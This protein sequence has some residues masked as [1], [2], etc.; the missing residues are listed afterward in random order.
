MRIG[1]DARFFGPQGTGP[2]RYVQRLV[3]HLG[4]LDTPHTFVLFM[5]REGAN[6]YAPRGERFETVIA[7]Y[8]WYSVAEQLRMP[9][10][11]DRADL[12]LMHFPHFNVPV[13]YRKPFV[14]T[15]HDLI[16]THFATKRATTLGPIAYAFKQAGYRYVIR[17]AARHA[18][19]IL[20]VSEYSKRELVETFQL[21]PEH[22]RVTYEATDPPRELDEEAAGILDRYDVRQPFLLYVG[23]TYPHK[24]LERFIRGYA[25]YRERVTGPL[26]LVLVGKRDYFSRRLEA[27]ATKLGLHDAMQFVG[28]I[29]DAEL[30]AFYQAATW[31]VF[32]SLYEGFGLPPLEAMSYGTPVLSSNATCL[33]EILGDA[34]RY[35]SPYRS[36][37]IADALAE[38]HTGTGAHDA[39]R[40]QARAHVRQ[41]SWKRMAEETL[42]VYETVGTDLRK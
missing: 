10:V 21:D 34:V 38:A 4:R 35:F 20:T 11:L 31:Y 30:P 16:I 8:R 27:E 22:V 2:G 12:D 1:I 32:P 24:N 9:R 36:A 19:R 37:D 6:A 5:Q 29:P 13:R 14:V 28:F 18:R 26:G 25:R 40:L 33:P 41:Y 42:G 15:I 23:N 17:H 7:D 39:R 3:E